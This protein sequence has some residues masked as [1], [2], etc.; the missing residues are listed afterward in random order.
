[1]SL[2]LAGI[3]APAVK[4]QTM[5]VSDI[6][7]A[8]TAKANITFTSNGVANYTDGSYNWYTAPL[9]NIGASYEIYA[10]VSS[11]PSG[12]FVGTLGSWLSL[13]TSRSWYLSTAA[14]DDTGSLQI[15][16]RKTGVAQVLATGIV[17][18]SVEV[19]V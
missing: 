19:I 11:A 10:E 13:S 12:S 6:A 8:M 1:M 16:I 9:L 4:V 17:T 2:L 7:L 15:S 18:F 14:G 3:S 5:T